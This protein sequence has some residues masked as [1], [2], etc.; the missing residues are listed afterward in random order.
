MSPRKPNRV[1]ICSLLTAEDR[2]GAIAQS[3]QAGDE[4]AI[5]GFLL[6]QQQAW[7]ASRDEVWGRMLMVSQPA[8]LSLAPVKPLRCLPVAAHSNYGSTLLIFHL[9]LHRVVRDAWG[10]LGLLGDFEHQVVNELLSG[11]VAGHGRLAHL[12]TTS[13]SHLTPNICRCMQETYFSVG[14][15][16]VALLPLGTIH[17]ILK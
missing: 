5:T 7:T 14:V 13:R 16:G 8:H 2:L 15:Q 1:R 6:L 9:L 11:G 4:R 3:I 10:S 17:I 12:R